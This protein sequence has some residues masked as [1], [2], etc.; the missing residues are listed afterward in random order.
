MVGGGHLLT[1]DW[2]LKGLGHSHHDVGAEYLE[3]EDRSLKGGGWARKAVPRLLDVVLRCMRVQQGTGRAQSTPD[4]HVVLGKRKSEGV[5][6]RPSTGPS[7]AACLFRLLSLLRDKDPRQ[8]P[9]PLAVP[10]KGNT[11]PEHS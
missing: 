8:L 4:I 1:F 5:G 11:Q 7:R 9:D 2:C 10:Q 3:G 6:E